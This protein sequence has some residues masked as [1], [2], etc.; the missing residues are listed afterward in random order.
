[1]SVRR[2]IHSVAVALIA[3]LALSACSG[4][5]VTGSVNPGF[6][7]D[8]IPDAPDFV[9]A[10]DGPQAGMTPEQIVQGFIDAGTSPEGNWAIANLFLAEG[11]EWRPQA[12]VYIDAPGNERLY[13]D[14]AEG[15]ISVTVTQTAGVD[16]TGAF[17]ASDSVATVLPFTLAQQDDGEWRITG[18]PDGVVLER[19]LFVRVFAA[20]PVMFFDPDWQY[21]VPDVRWFPARTNAATRISQAL[22]DGEPT[23]WLGASVASAFPDDVALAQASVT[24][25]GDRVATVQLDG[26]ALAL[27][28]VTIDRMQAQLE[29]SLAAVGVQTVQMTADGAEITATAAP[30]RSTRVASNPLVLNEAGFGF[31]SGDE[32][33]P[34]PGLS[35]AI[36]ALED[37][38]VAIEVSATRTAAAVRV[39]SGAVARVQADGG[40]L[41]VDTRAA[42]IDPSIDSKGYVWT[43]PKGAPSAVTVSGVEGGPATLVADAWPEATE[44]TSLR[45]SRDGTRVAA[46]IA[47]GAQNWVVVAG[48]VRDGDGVPVRLTESQQIARLAGAGVAAAWLDDAN[49]GVVSSE[50][51]TIT[52]TQ[53]LVGGEAT[54][55][56]A[57]SGVTSVAGA[58][59]IS[60]LRLRDDTGALY[61]RRGSN[62]GQTASGIAVLASQQGQP[63]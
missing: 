4:L 46:L 13:T 45:L 18:A 27:E 12:Q 11:T 33:T 42:L 49:L 35:D 28:Q 39:A 59:Q 57:P 62:W 17:T 56:E 37:T 32:L 15:E 19:D 55:I 40:V 8:Q 58:N 30:T 25:D 21:L 26:R 61:V 36:T 22:I 20:Y 31:L 41:E 29:A 16:G 47:V 6:A 43:V 3:A 2:R 7:A 5:P 60:A 53:M 52:V 50:A 54:R 10:P 23:S 51:G 38:P 63:Q 48:V 24:V 14:V 1:M 34:I 9:F 44:I